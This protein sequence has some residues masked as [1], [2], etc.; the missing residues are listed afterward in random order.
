MTNVLKK[1]DKNVNTRIL[2]LLGLWLPVVFLTLIGNFSMLSCDKKSPVE[3]EIEANISVSV[4]YYDFSEV[5]VGGNSDY[6]IIVSN[7]G[8]ANLT[9]NTI[10]CDNTAFNILSSDCPQTIF[11]GKSIK[12]IVRF[13]PPESK[14]YTGT[15]KIISNDP[16]EPEVSVLLKGRGIEPLSAAAFW[17]PG[18]INSYW[19]YNDYS[20]VQVTATLV[21]NIEFNGKEYKVVEE[22]QPFLG[23][24]S[25]KPD[26]DPFLVFRYENTTDQIQGYGVAVNKH[27]ERTLT[28]LFTEAGIPEE[29]IDMQPP[30]DEW[31]LLKTP[32]VGHRWTV[33]RFYLEA[34]SYDEKV[35]G[36][37]E[38]ESY[39]PRKEK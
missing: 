27:I 38:I 7:I 34:T 2:K 3:S 39:I 1:E 11:P 31:V 8:D 37:F 25:T 26:P 9:I 17:Y 13:S 12:I 19:V 15:L 24:L 5:T 10:N 35:S 21:G 18:D 6:E 30:L 14:S 22:S 4:K 36:F 16:N 33:M 32:I 29:I 20:F 28:S 23:T